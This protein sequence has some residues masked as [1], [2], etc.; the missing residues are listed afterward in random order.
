[1]G[2]IAQNNEKG[3][4]AGPLFLRPEK[5]SPA[6]LHKR[7]SHQK[8]GLVLF[9]RAPGGLIVVLPRLGL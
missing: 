8:P 3:A 5:Q 2:N 4:L 6:T 1:M 9:Q 7:L